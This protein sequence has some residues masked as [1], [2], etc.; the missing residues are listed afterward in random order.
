[1]LI[2]SATPMTLS[3]CAKKRPDFYLR[4]A[5]QV[6]DRLGLTLNAKKT[7]ITECYSRTFD[8]LGH[9]FYGSAIEADGKTEYVL[10]SVTQSDDS[11]KEKVRGDCPYGT[12]WELPLLIKER[13]NRSYEVVT[14]SRWGTH[15]TLHEHRQ[16]HHLH[17]LHHAA[18]EAQEN[19]EGWRDHPPSWF[20]DYH[21]LFNVVRPVNSQ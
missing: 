16:L 3:S 5:G 13:I 21:G 10:L 8:F 2:S 6:L 18:E 4:T 12:H 14:T 9:P 17:T 1:M 20:Y 19:V 11:I 7:R 15:G